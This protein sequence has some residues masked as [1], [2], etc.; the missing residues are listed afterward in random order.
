MASLTIYPPI[1]DSSMDAFIAGDNS[2]C[3]VYFSLSKFNVY[4]DFDNVH[5]SIKKQ[6]TGTTVVKNAANVTI[7]GDTYYTATG[8]VLNV[9]KHSVEGQ[10]NLYYIDI[11]NDLLQDGWVP[12][13]IYCIQ[14]RLSDATYSPDDGTQS[15]WLNAHGS[16]FSEWSTVCI[17]KATGEP[18]ITIPAFNFKGNTSMVNPYIVDNLDFVGSYSNADDPSETLSNYRILLYKASD[19]TNCLEDSGVVYTKYTNQIWYTFHIEPMNNTEYTI[20]L[21]YETLN[22]YTNTLVLKA[23][24][25]WQ[26][27]AETPFKI[28]LAEDSSSIY[29]ITPSQESDYGFIG[30]KVYDESD[31]LSSDTF[32]IRRASSKD[33]FTTWNDI[34][35]ITLNNEKVNEREVICDFTIESGVWYKYGIQTLAD[36]TRGPLKVNPV[37]ALREFEYTFLL[38]EENKQLRLQL[39]NNADSLKINVNDTITPTINGIYPY[40]SRYG[41]NYYKT[42]N[43]SGIISFNMD[44][45]FATKEDVF[46]YVDIVGLYKDYNNSNG[47]DKY[48][49]IYEKFFRDEVMKFLYDGK[50]KLYKSQTEGTMIV[51]LRNITLS[52]QQNLNRLFFSFTA[53][54]T[55]VAEYNQDNLLK[56]KL[57]NLESKIGDNIELTSIKNHTSHKEV[58]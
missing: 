52:P 39:N 7:D 32:I 56:Y 42:F 53:T 35:Q 5:V 49:Y 50:I 6:T 28:I 58:I 51:R 48:D 31:S 13:W 34:K 10:K 38:G 16:D 8:I 14:L 18:T 45:Y 20:I 57:L 30:L 41:K 12:G 44:E 26:E 46:K 40:N 15:S 33:N 36:G 25:R 24:A 55:E 9:P 23:D 21:I 27:G 4:E 11:K 17:I 19:L 22:G 37:P 54:V 43:T 1:V 29:N 3:R 2:S 47:I